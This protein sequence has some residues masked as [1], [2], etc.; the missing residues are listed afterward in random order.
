M[1]NQ[2]D[3]LTKGISNANLKFRRSENSISIAISEEGLSTNTANL[4]VILKTTRTEI[5]NILMVVK[6]ECGVSR[7]TLCVNHLIIDFVSYD[8]QI[9][10]ILA[11]RSKFLSHWST[12]NCIASIDLLIESLLEEIVNIEKFEFK[13]FQNEIFTTSPFQQK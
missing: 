11:S 9:N 6:L 2:T 10:K 1:L 12:C 4:P 7:N 5:Y 3:V 13:I 8:F